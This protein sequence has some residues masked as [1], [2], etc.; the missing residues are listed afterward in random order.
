MAELPL[1]H[2]HEDGSLTYRL[3]K[4]RKKTL[5]LD[6]PQYTIAGL[7]KIHPYTFSLYVN[8]KKDISDKHLKALCKVLNCTPDDI[9][10]Y[11][12]YPIGEA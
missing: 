3:T 4:L 12:D 11:E 10:G 9:L 7:A 5:S 1:T 6:V 2:R 8:G